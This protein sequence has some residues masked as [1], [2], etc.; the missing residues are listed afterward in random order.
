MAKRAKK[1][2][3]LEVTLPITQFLDMTFQLLFF[4]MATFNPSPI[5]GEMDLALPNP[6]AEAK[7]NDPNKIN[8]EAKAIAEI[9]DLVFDLTVVVKPAT[10]GYTLSLTEGAV[11][12]PI[13]TKTPADTLRER[14]AKK[15]KAREDSI[16]EKAKD[17]PAKDRDEWLKKELVKQGVKVVGGKDLPWAY[18]LEVLDIVN[19]SGW[20]TITLGPPY[21]Y[22]VS[23]VD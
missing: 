17:M 14:L 11:D 1:G 3:E 23:A 2:E 4:F 15:W 6:K 12:T 16:N 7:A 10:D 18:V 9:D 21:D 22:R 8:R 13:A 19:K 5:E 20:K